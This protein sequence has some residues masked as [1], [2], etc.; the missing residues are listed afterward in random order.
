[1][2]T[3]IN[4]ALLI[5]SSAATLAAF[6]GDTWNKGP[7]PL[8]KRI[9]RRGWIS[10]ICLVLSLA[11]GIFQALRAQKLDSQRLADEAKLVQAALER[12]RYMHEDHFTPDIR[13]YFTINEAIKTF[14]AGH[15]QE[16]LAKINGVISLLNKGGPSIEGVRERAYLSRAQFYLQLHRYQDVVND[17]E[18]VANDKLDPNLQGVR[19]D[20]EGRALLQLGQSEDALKNFAACTQ[21]H[22]DSPDC[23]Q[24]AALSNLSLKNFR[25]A[26]DVANE[27]LAKYGDDAQLLNLRRLALEGLDLQKNAASLSNA[28]DGVK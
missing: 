4:I 20:L 25:G 12:D 21:I 24:G 14:E 16:A 15:T 5:I 28:G 1:M 27:G 17:C 13:E 11:L 2:T 9:N 26:L 10:L 3:L 19:Y 23:Y 18:E 6:G 8:L 7:E 22:L